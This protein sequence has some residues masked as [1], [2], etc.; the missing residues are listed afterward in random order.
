M[1][2][3][4]NLPIVEFHGQRY[5][6]VSQA[7]NHLRLCKEAMEAD[8]VINLPKLKS[9]MQLTLTMGVKNLF[10]C[11]PGKMKAWLLKEPRKIYAQ[12]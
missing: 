2:S 8:V 1:I 9:H 11:V 3:Q 10:G 7:F 12:R 4:L 6:T 5:Q